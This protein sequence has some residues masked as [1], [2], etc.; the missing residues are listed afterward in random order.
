M[1]NSDKHILYRDDYKITYMTNIIQ[2][3]HQRL[4]IEGNYLFY[5]TTK[6]IWELPVLRYHR[7]RVNYAYPFLG[8]IFG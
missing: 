7:I 1:H 3:N 6:H 5:L 8:V 2:E 4:S